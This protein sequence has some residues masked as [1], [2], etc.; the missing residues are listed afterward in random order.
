MSTTDDLVALREAAGGRV[1]SVGSVPPKPALKYPYVVIGY[2][3]G[4]PATRD[5]GGS[6][7]PEPRFTV[8]HFGKTEDGLEDIA[9]LT[10]TTFD[11]AEIYPG[12]TCWQ[13]LATPV[14][15][16][17]DDHGVLNLTH[18]YRY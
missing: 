7:E 3:P 13:E 14:F 6:G 8:Q 4:Q 18:T 5:L 1:Y 15:R 16:D 2:A 9:S 17:A 11:N 12:R 10:F